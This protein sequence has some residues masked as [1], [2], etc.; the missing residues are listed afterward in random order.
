M[1]L[2]GAIW[3]VPVWKGRKNYLYTGMFAYDMG[4]IAYRITQTQGATFLTFQA[5]CPSPA[6]PHMW[7]NI[8]RQVAYVTGNIRAAPFIGQK[9]SADAKVAN[10]MWRTGHK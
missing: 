1:G 2:R 7:R 5:P 10:S 6:G 3:H 4:M 9:Q 8:M